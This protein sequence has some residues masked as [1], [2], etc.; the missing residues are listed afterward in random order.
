MEI[1][2]GRA[3]D[4]AAIA[5]MLQ[6]L[7]DDIGDGDIFRTDEATIRR[8]GFGTA[9]LFHCMI[10]TQD[11]AY[12]GLALYFPGFS[13]TMAAPGLYVQD[14]WVSGQA[15]GAGLGKRLLAA[16]AAHAAETW[17]AQYLALTVYEDNPRAQKFY[18]SLGFTA[19]ESENTMRLRGGS[20]QALKALASAP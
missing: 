2:M 4:A 13:T 7:A 5:G 11:Q 9:P 17:G 20:F 16:A 6:A 12:T 3:E 15:R 10:A 8:H 18:Q 1:R 19:Q 14:L